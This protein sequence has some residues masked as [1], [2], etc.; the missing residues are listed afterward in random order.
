MQQQ[1]QAAR[2]AGDAEFRRGFYRHYGTILR[3]FWSS[4]L[5]KRPSVTASQDH[6]SD[7][8]VTPPSTSPP[9]AA[10]AAPRQQCLLAAR[11]IH[12][13]EAKLIAPRVM[14]HSWRGPDYNGASAKPPRAFDGRPSIRPAPRSSFTCSLCGE[15]FRVD[16]HGRKPP[17]CP[18]LVFMED[19][20]CMRDPFSIGGGADAAGDVSA[21]P[22][23]PHI[24]LLSV[25]FATASCLPSTFR[26]GPFSLSVTHERALGQLGLFREAA[27]L[28]VCT[29]KLSHEANVFF[30]Q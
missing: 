18:Q 23:I 2:L 16:Y 5:P 24:G 17:F 30:N 1:Q 6:Y 13:F 10:A 19:V 20:F 28:L 12:T 3:S 26:R 29:I 8:H 9:P 22:W 21:V 27:A 25:A 14:G 15:C 7:V 4:R 11:S